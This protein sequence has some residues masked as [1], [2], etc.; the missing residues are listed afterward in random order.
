[1]INIII[2]WVL[3]C[4]YIAIYCHIAPVSDTV[5]PRL[6]LQI[7]VAQMQFKEERIFVMFEHVWDSIYAFCPTNMFWGKAPWPWFVLYQCLPTS[8]PKSWILPN[9]STQDSP[10]TGFFCDTVF[11]DNH[12]LKLKSFNQRWGQ[13]EAGFKKYMIQVWEAQNNLNLEVG[14]FR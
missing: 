9:L 2:Y 11:D 5:L 3:E 13:N 14:D 7:I 4:E 8:T 10:F 1:M 6:S 12:I